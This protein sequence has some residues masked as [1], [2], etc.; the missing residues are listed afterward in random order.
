MGFIHTEN[1]CL[2]NIWMIISKFDLRSDKLFFR[3]INSAFR[4]AELVI[5]TC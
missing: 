4:L 1:V 5:T 2:Y 3:Q